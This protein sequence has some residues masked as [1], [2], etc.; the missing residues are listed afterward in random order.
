MDC[1]D[2]HNIVQT[3]RQRQSTFALAS[4]KPSTL[5]FA[6]SH[7]VAFSGIDVK[8]VNV[9]VQISAGETVSFRRTGI[10]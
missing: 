8:D 10:E 5:N 6:R 2:D 7:T 9:Q 3:I 4:S 1:H